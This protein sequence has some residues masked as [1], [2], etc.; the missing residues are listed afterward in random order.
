MK[1]LSKEHILMLHSQLIDGYVDRFGDIVNPVEYTRA[2]A[3]SEGI[4]AVQKNESWY[5][6]E[7]V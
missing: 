2:A 7:L 4:A 5:I 6:I 1:R 3:F